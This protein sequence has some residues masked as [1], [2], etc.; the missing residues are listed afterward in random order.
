MEAGGCA[1]RVCYDAR[2]VVPL[3]YPMSY[4]AVRK[5]FGLSRSVAFASIDG[6]SRQKVPLLTIATVERSGPQSMVIFHHRLLPEG[7]GT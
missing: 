2:K 7:D 5:T 4:P 1:D 3:V 6:V